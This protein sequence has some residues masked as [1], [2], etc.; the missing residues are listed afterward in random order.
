[1]APQAIQERNRIKELDPYF[2]QSATFVQDLTIEGCKARCLEGTR[3]AALQEIQDWIQDDKGP[4]IYWLSAMSGTG[5]ST[6]ARTVAAALVSKSNEAQTSNVKCSLAAGF[7]FSKGDDSRNTAQHVFTTILR[8][9]TFHRP[10]MTK[11]VAEACAELKNVMSKG[12]W[13]LWDVFIRKLPKFIEASQTMSKTPERWIVVIDALDECQNTTDSDIL[14]ILER[15]SKCNTHL[16]SALLQIRFLVTSRTEDHIERAFGRLETNLYR[17]EILKMVNVVGP[18]RKMLPDNDVAIYF[19]VNLRSIAGEQFFPTDEQWPGED[20]IEKLVMKSQGLFIYAATC[21]RFLEFDAKRRLGLLLEEDNDNEETILDSDETTNDSD[22]TINDPGPQ[23]HLFKMYSQVIKDCRE[24]GEWTK[25]DLNKLKDILGRLIVLAEPVSIHVLNKL[26]PKEEDPDSLRKRLK[27]FQS[28]IHIPKDKDI[29]VTLH[30]LS[31]HNFLVCKKKKKTYRW[32]TINEMKTNTRMLERCLEIFKEFLR[33]QDIC[34]VRLPGTEVDELSQDSIQ[35]SIPLHLRYAC[36]HWVHHLSRS[37][38]ALTS[39]VSEKVYDFLKSRFLFWVE[40]MAWMREMSATVAVVVQLREIFKP[41][42][43]PVPGNSDDCVSLIAEFAKDAR[44]FLLANRS[45]VESTPLQLYCSALLFSPSK[46]VIR[47]LYGAEHIPSWIKRHPQVAEHWDPRLSTLEGAGYTDVRISADTTVIAATEDNSISLW[48]ISTWTKMPALR[49]N[50]RGL[51]IRSIALSGRGDAMMLACV[52]KKSESVSEQTRLSPGVTVWDVTSGDVILAVEHIDA[53]QV[54]FS[55]DARILTSVGRNGTIKSWNVG[56]GQSCEAHQPA[57]LWQERLSTLARPLEISPDGQKVAFHLK[58]PDGVGI[59]NIQSDALETELPF[60]NLKRTAWSDDGSLLAAIS[61]EFGGVSNFLEIWSVSTWK[62]I[63]HVSFQEELELVAISPDNSVLALGGWFGDCQNVIMLVKASDG[64][65]LWASPIPGSPWG[66][67]SFSP[68]GQYLVSS[69]RSEG[70]VVW[71]VATCK[72]AG[73]ESR[74]NAQDTRGRHRSWHLADS[75]RIHSAGEFIYSVGYETSA[76]F[77]VVNGAPIAQ[78]VTFKAATF[79]SDGRLACLS[80]L[81]RRMDDGYST[82]ASLRLWDMIEDR[83]VQG[84]ECTDVLDWYLS[85]ETLTLI[86]DSGDSNREVRVV[87]LDDMRIMHS[88]H[89]SGQDLK[90]PLCLGTT[91]GLVAYTTGDSWAEECTLNLWNLTTEAV[92]CEVKYNCDCSSTRIPEYRFSPNGLFFF[93]LCGPGKLQFREV[94]TGEVRFEKISVGEMRKR[95]PLS[96]AC[97]PC[98]FS[99][100]PLSCG[101]GDFRRQTVSSEHLADTIR[102]S[103]NTSGTEEWKIAIYRTLCKWKFASSQARRVFRPN[104]VGLG[105]R[106][107]LDGQIPWKLPQFRGAKFV[108]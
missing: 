4:P 38:A 12:T 1:M 32:L 8:C 88:L 89:V 72:L 64:G 37:G 21:C 100:R 40:A 95:E 77:R 20:A 26:L 17:Q 63:I 82:G 78:D 5:K 68:D 16:N 59:W 96:D 43:T 42:V 10:E 73:D 45:I 51:N 101:P 94:P 65:K 92:G 98:L 7:F 85:S 47:K 56:Q 76:L 15:F 9:F 71:D 61:A 93:H 55:P 50:D 11:F 83:E 28:V 30:H 48:N 87:S 103:K 108:F 70:I 67:L 27:D 29:P 66:R 80:N 36:R 57:T 39:E 79:S 19:R 14:Q 84:G 58:G 33:H 46:S 99:R 3:T 105:K 69:I 54:Q 31:F 18:D 52:Y 41:A 22:E 90:A 97:P 86:L 24:K 60:N 74:T 6:V 62:T 104:D 81:D 106:E 34:V 91:D 13:G 75:L 107:V 35:R 44:R 53:E 102:R 23:S 25:S 2:Q 49:L